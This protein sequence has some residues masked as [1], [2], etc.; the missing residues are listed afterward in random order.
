[1]KGLDRHVYLFSLGHFSVDWV[2][3]AIP[4]LLPYFI[5]VCQLNY[6]EATTLIFAN[7]LLS[8][9]SQ[10]LFGY[11]S[12]KISKPW[13]V[14]LGPVICG[15]C[16]TVIAFTTDYWII[17]I[18]SMFSGLGSSIFHPEA[19]RLVNRIAGSLKGQAL[20]SFSVGGNAGF[21]V[22]PVAAGLCAYSLGI[23]GLVVFGIINGL[24]AF[25]LYRRMPS[26]LA[27]AQAADV[28][29][30]KAHPHEGKEN[31]WRS[32]GKLTV[33]IFARSIGFA[34]CN[35]FIPL[36]W[37]NVL[38]TSAAQGS[39]ALSLLF[40]LGVVITFAGGL[41]ADR[42]GFIRVMRLSFLIMVPA[43]FFFVNSTN[44]WISTLL[45]I[46]VGLSLFAPYSSIVVLGQ[47]FLGKNVGFASGITLGLSTTVGGILSPLVGWGAD[48]WGIPTALQVLWI[49][50]AVG[51]I[52]SF[53]V[54]APQERHFR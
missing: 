44:V 29:E 16:L 8:S 53:L 21:A 33:V 54:N 50:A 4:A 35:A 12:D 7:M 43:M 9:V 13:F 39:A 19:A 38:H 1:M 41:L 25:F 42:L 24:L 47:T 3:G 27:L 17:F 34:L 52:F 22:G 11:Y 51:A 37:I 49:C 20:G 23:H 45:L 6:R 14:P 28:A 30:N 46:P 26:V 18:C 2:Q 10:P 40:I 48:Q 32:F 5:T 36:Y 31:D 15:L